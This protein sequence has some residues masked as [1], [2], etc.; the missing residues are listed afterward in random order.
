MS[1]LAEVDKAIFSTVSGRWQKVV[2][3]IAKVSEACRQNG[4]KSDDRV[5]ADRIEVLIE[6]GRLQCQGAPKLWR[7]SEVR[8]TVDG[9]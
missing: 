6:Q 7:Y 1:S 3:I 2:M 9:D 5:I 4:I 8:S